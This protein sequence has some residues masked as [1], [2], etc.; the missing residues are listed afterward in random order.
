MVRYF[1]VER[2]SAGPIVVPASPWATIS[3][4]ISGGN[5][6]DT[7]ATGGPLLCGPLSAPF[8]GVW[9]EGTSF[10]AAQ[11]E[12][13]YLRL[14]FGVDAAVMTNNPAMLADVAPRLNTTGLQDTLQAN[15]DPAAWVGALGDWLLRLLL[16]AAGGEPFTVPRHLLGL[17]TADLADQF[18]LGVRQLERRYLAAYGM[19]LRES[20]RMHR[21][22]DYLVHLSTAAT[23]KRGALPWVKIQSAGWVKF[24]SAPTIFWLIG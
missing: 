2:D 20:R 7:T 19:P 15:A 1:H 6:G 17:S 13:R 4:F 21:Y 14:L 9:R 12:P 22:V 16:G 23:S 8:P 3:F 24:Q 11:L 18:G 10:V 5:A